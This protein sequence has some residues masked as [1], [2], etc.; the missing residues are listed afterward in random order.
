[1]D[2]GGRVQWGGGVQEA[3]TM[4]PSRD[5]GRSDGLLFGSPFGGRGLGHG[6]PG[7]VG[8]QGDPFVSELPANPVDLFRETGI[9]DELMEPEMATILAAHAER[10]RTT[11]AAPDLTPLVD[12]LVGDRLRRSP[13]RSPAGAGRVIA[14]HGAGGEGAGPVDEVASGSRGAR[15]VAPATAGDAGSPAVLPS[16]RAGSRIIS[17]LGASVSPLRPGEVPVAGQPRV[18]TGA[19]VRSPGASLSPLL[20][21]SPLV[22]PAMGSGSKRTRSTGSHDGGSEGRS[23]IGGQSGGGGGPPRVRR[24]ILPQ[25]VTGSVDAAG[26]AAPAAFREEWDGAQSNRATI[27]ASHLGKSSGPPSRAPLADQEQQQPSGEEVGR[28]AGD[29][30]DELLGLVRY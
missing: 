11:G 8:S 24:R 29:E 22:P 20:G 18:R 4:S 9:L 30:I 16:T 2:G 23:S 21:N 26:T 19:G 15:A 14:E 5:S 6:S 25:A 10:A 7:G 27:G 28:A 1:L 13:S 17:E 3:M 12:A